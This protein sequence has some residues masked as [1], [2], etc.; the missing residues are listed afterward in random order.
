MKA[1]E[2][3]ILISFFFLIGMIGA[4]QLHGGWPVLAFWIGSFVSGIT[5]LMLI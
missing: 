4:M 3:L 2:I 1:R 5:Y